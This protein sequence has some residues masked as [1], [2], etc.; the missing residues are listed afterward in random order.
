MSKR[1][2][3][4]LSEPRKMTAAELSARAQ[5]DP[6]YPQDYVWIVTDNK[7]VSFTDDTAEGALAL[8]KQYHKGR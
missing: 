5:Q 3:V 6:R 2:T 1:K 7:N 8:A 4:V